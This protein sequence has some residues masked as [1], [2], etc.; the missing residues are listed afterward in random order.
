M[1]YN[2]RILVMD[3]DQAILDIFASVLSD[4]SKRQQ[5]E[6]V[7]ALSALLGV[8][9]EPDRLK[10]R[11]FDVETAQQGELGFNKVKAALAAGKP[12]SV[13][14]TD[15]RMPPGWDGVQAAKEIRQVDA[16]VGIIIVTAF[17]DAT[18]SEIVRKVGF[19][20]RLLYLKKPFD[21]E[22]IL[23][24]ADSLSMRWNL[25]EKVRNLMGVLEGMLDSFIELKMAYY[26]DEELRPFLTQTLGHISQFLDTPDVF[27]ARFENGEVTLKIG[28]GRF[29]NGLKDNPVFQNFLDTVISSNKP[30]D[31]ILRIDQYV[32][33]PIFCQRY[34]NIVVGLLSEQ[35]I[36]GADQ[37]LEVL[38]KD[39]SKVFET[40]EALSQMRAEAQEKD[41]TI[42]LLE[43]KI[44]A[45]EARKGL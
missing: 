38:A 6:N 4:Q 24:L 31:K 1:G 18:I 9:E 28:L 7:A 3:D 42:R 32:V 2:N 43:A 39:M 25:E 34:H 17:S 30:I 35:E 44:K 29:A 20:D 21:D 23:Q 26:R 14:F 45:C 40:V 15:M 13:V 37:L 16:A 27:L 11:V 12:Y 41:E 10:R 19:T 36:E 5:S 33:L 8:E 22:E